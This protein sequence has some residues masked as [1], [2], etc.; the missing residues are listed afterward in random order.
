VEGVSDDGQGA[1]RAAAVSCGVGPGMGWGRWQSAVGGGGAPGGGGVYGSSTLLRLD[2]KRK[3]NRSTGAGVGKRGVG[4]RFLKF[5]G[6]RYIRRLTDE[7]TGPTFVG[8][9]TEEY[10]S[11]IFLSIE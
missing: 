11:F 9:E 5:V 8:F 1:R 6:P 3:R 10:T 4:Y 7:C 2:K